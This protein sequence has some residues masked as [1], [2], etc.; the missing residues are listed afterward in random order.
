MIEHILS[1]QA[2]RMTLGSSSGGQPNHY[3]CS[4]FLCKDGKYI[5]ISYSI[6]RYG[7]KINFDDSGYIN[8]VLY[9]TAEN[10][11]DF[12]GGH[13]N[14]SSISNLPRKIIEMFDNY[15]RYKS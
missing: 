13:N 7:E 9:R 5:Y 14:F 2:L 3:D 11:H 12:H 4:G 1:P 6:P 8:G 10:D 15:D